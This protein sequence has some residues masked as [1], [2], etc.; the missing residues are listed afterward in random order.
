MS[1]VFVPG[2]EEEGLVLERDLPNVLQA[3]GMENHLTESHL[4]GNRDPWIPSING[5]LQS[6]SRDRINL[7]GR[8]LSGD[9]QLFEI[10]HIAA[11]YAYLR[12]EMEK[13][14]GKGPGAAIP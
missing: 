14:K 10:E 1:D 11:D 12:G 7:G 13:A 2:P 8:P 4:R 3:S 5:R 9:E 6:T